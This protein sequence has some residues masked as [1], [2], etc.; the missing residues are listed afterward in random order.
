VQAG[1]TLKAVLIAG[2][3]VDSVFAASVGPLDD[4]FGDSDL[5]LP[6]GLINAKVEG[7]IQNDNAVPNDP[8]QAFFAK[9]VKLS[10]GPVTPPH[11]IEAPFPN[12]GAAPSGSRIS[13][14]LL[15][16]NPDSPR[17]KVLTA[18]NLRNWYHRRS[19]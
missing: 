12:A 13:K 11:V 18:E 1:G 4:Q 6:H 17:R 14:T 19:N 3:V 15:P 8:T 2:D 5:V 16:T 10:R 7:T 9:T